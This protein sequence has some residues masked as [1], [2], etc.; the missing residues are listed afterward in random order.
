MTTDL[1]GYTTTVTFYGGKTLTGTIIGKTIGDCK[2]TRWDIR[3]EDGQI[4]SYAANSKPVKTAQAP[5]V[6][7]PAT[8]TGCGNILMGSEM[9]G[10]VCN[11]CLN[12]RIERERLEAREHELT[13]DIERAEVELSNAKANLIGA[14]GNMHLNAA[15]YATK[16]RNH[17]RAVAQAGEYLNGLR[18]LLASTR[19]ALAPLTDVEPRYAEVAAELTPEVVAAQDGLIA[20]ERAYAT[21]Q[22]KG[23]SLL[24]SVAKLNLDSWQRQYQRAVDAQLAHAFD[25]LG[26]KALKER[27][28]SHAV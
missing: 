23:D 21:A 16:V 27:E 17:A 20:A 25:E 26:E 19:R 3:L 28:A 6:E 13:E 15:D 7:A 11:E 8:C 24:T 22:A 1:T 14:A 2:A 12:T 9:R 4:R 18:K 10:T 5:V